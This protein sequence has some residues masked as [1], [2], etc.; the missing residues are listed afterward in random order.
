MRPS[1]YLRRP[2]EC[3]LCGTEIPAGVP[4]VA[5]AWD[6]TGR[7]W[8]HLRPSCEDLAGGKATDVADSDLEVREKAPGTEI[9]EPDPRRSVG[10]VPRD[11]NSG[12]WSV[13]VELHESEVDPA[14][15]KRVVRIARLYLPTLEAALDVVEETGERM[16]AL[17]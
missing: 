14:L 1:Q 8:K 15:R 17:R 10:T 13:T 9:G 16:Q 3:Q 6:S 7:A 4:L 12:P 11:S 2:A 5:L